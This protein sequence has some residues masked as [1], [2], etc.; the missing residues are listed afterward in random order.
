MNIETEV[1]L[2]IENQDVIKAKSVLNHFVGARFI[3]EQLLINQYFDTKALQLLNWNMGLR[4]R[5][6]A[7][8]KEQ[9]IK[10]AGKVVNGLHQRPE[11]NID[12]PFEY[13]V[14]DLALFPK[15]IWPDD[16]PLSDIQAQ[17]TVLFETNFNRSKWHYACGAS[18]IEVAL[19]VGKILANGKQS[20]ICEIELELIEGNETDLLQLAAEFTN[21]ISARTGND[22][23]A[24]RGYEL[25]L[26]S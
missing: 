24:K 23:K 2:I 15:E 17:L 13:T 4:I 12:I 26:K 16:T 7:Q 21:Q 5:Q 14:P 6:I 20:Q 25:T 1:K 18:T 10:T 8:Q 9:T 22:S 19:D 3:N 11:Y